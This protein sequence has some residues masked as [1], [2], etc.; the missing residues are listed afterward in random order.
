MI[1]D[2]D[3]IVMRGL[4]RCRDAADNLEE[5]RPSASNTT[6]NPTTDN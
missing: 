1:D 6:L 4:F 3:E 2:G 5:V